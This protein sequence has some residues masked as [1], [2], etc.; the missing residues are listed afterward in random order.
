V[1]AIFQD[2]QQAGRALAHI[3]RDECPGDMNPEHTIVLG[4]PRGGVPVAFEV[5]R[6]LHLPLDVFVVRKLGVPGH[7][8]LAMGAIASGGAVVIQSEVVSAYRIGQETID[9]VAARERLEI[10]RR[11]A[12]YRTGR[13]P[14]RLS[15]STVILIDDGLATGSTMKAAARALRPIA[16]RI[17][18]AIPVAAASTCQDLRHEVD[19]LV[20]LQTPEPF[21]A[22]GE[23][24][25]NFGQTTDAEVR[26]LLSQGQE[27]SRGRRATS[28]LW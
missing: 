2:R 28:S 26:A 3:V 23:F 9:A 22:V 20:C 14:L 10:E 18:V 7:E 15:G 6:E 1:I 21:Y 27:T 16:S 13:P 12:A 5:A 24:Y 19:Q 11:E 25:R 8:E 17:V 4:L